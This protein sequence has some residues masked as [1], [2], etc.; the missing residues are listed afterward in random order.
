MSDILPLQRQQILLKAIQDN[1]IISYKEL[2]YLVDVSEST[3]RRDLKELEGQELI[4][5]DRGAAV[6]IQRESSLHLQ[7]LNTDDYFL[8]KEAIGKA[9]AS[10][11]KNGETIILDSGTT[12]LELAK[13]IDP[14]I[15]IT[16]VTNALLIAVELGKKPNVDVIVVGGSINH[17]GQALAGP[18]A[19]SN[20]QGIHAQK[21]FLGAAGITE[22][23]GVSNYNLNLIEVRKAMIEISEEAIVLADHS[24][25]G[26]NGLASVASLTNIQRI[27]TS[28]G[29]SEKDQQM[30]SKYHVEAII[31]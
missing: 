20:L 1:G 31:V 27:I 4:R 19:I 7:S 8:E 9:A 30:L 5:L 6:C 3:L 2:K 24:K 29:I 23:M 10:L 22:E 11:I 13:S 25:F 28:W 21:V 15:N 18:L 26:R 12:T 14:G 16:C 17:T